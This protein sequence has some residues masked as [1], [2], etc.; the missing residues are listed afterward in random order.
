MYMH[1]IA[2]YR[3]TEYFEQNSDYISDTYIDN[4]QDSQTVILP[5]KKPIVHTCRWINIISFEKCGLLTFIFSQLFC[6]L[7]VRLSVELT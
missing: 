2:I 6:I 7:K 4:W 5:K 3:N 1:D